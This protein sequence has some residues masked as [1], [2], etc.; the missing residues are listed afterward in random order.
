MFREKKKCLMGVTICIACV[1]MT[2]CSLH[3]KESDTQEDV[4]VS[5]EVL[6]VSYS[7]EYQCIV[8]NGMVFEMDEKEKTAVVSSYYDVEQTDFVVPAQISYKDKLY[9]VTEIGPNAFESNPVLE[10]IRLGS[11]VEQI[12]GNAF[13]CCDQLNN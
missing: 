10:T 3:N 5:E 8:G 13:Y 9:S 1:L 4:S 12:R 2:A 7:Q 11:N 6:S